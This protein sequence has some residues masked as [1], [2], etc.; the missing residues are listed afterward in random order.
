MFSKL[1]FALFKFC[2]RAVDPMYMPAYKGSTLRGG[3]GTTFRRVVCVTKLPVCQPCQ[4]RNLC[5][6]SYVFE[7]P[8]VIAAGNALPTA[9]EP[10]PLEAAPTNDLHA[11]AQRTFDPHPFI[12]EPPLETKEIY[13]PGEAF[14][15]NLILVGKAIDYLPY[16]VFT[17]EEMGRTGIGRGRGRY[18]LEKVLAR[19]PQAAGQAAP[20]EPDMAL[21]DGHRRLFR[22]SHPVFHF[23]RDVLNEVAVLHKEDGA[24]DAQITLRFLTPTR[25]KFQNKLTSNIKFEIILRALLRRITLLSE[26]HCQEKLDLDYKKLIRE[27]GGSVRTVSS[28]LHWHDWERYSRRQ[29]TKMMMGGFRGDITFAGRLNDFLP[30]LILGKYLHIGK[31]T[32]YGLGKYEIVTDR[33]G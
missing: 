9:P 8:T 10:L 24:R 12:I 7:T 6:Y 33:R 28:S 13:Q 30:F 25:L 3:F 32:A 22:G 1:K 5:S 14:D 2:C 11:T 15:F 20:T 31:G 18:W 19:S 26:V 16:F 4:L 21:Y 29:Q 27:V 23:N 17:F